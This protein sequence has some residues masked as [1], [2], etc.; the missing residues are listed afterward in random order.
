[1]LRCAKKLLA[2]LINVIVILLSKWL[3]AFVSGTYIFLISL[4]IFFLFLP[5]VM[6]IQFSFIIGFNRNI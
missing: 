2:L 6:N 1:M 4:L 3:F 5:F